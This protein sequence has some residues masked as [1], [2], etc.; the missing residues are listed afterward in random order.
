MLAAQTDQHA[1]STGNTI[2]DAL[3]R[4]VRKHRSKT[5]L[6]YGGRA[7]SF[8]ALD[9]A[10]DRVARALLDA[11][12]KPGQR[13]GAF[14][15]NSDAYVLLWLACTRT[16]IVHVP[17]NYALGPKELRYILEQAVVSG[18]VTDDALAETADAACEG[19]EVGLRGSF[20]SEAPGE[21]DVLRVVRSDDDV[22][23]PEV[24]LDENAVAQFLYT[25][26]TTSLPKGAMMTH[27]AL[28]AEYM[29]CII[30]LD[31]KADEVGLAALP[32]YHSAQMHVFLMPSLL[33]G[34]TTVLI[35]APAPTACFEQIEAH[36]V[37]SFFAPPTVWI[38]LLRDEGFDTYDLS[39]LKKAY[40]GAS[41]MPTPVLQE[42]RERMP[43]V[44]LYNC[45][46]QSEIA[47][48]ATVLRPE[49]HEARPASAG[50]PLLTVTTRVVDEQMN[51]VAAGEHGEIVHRSPQLLVGYWDKP[52]R[53]EEA[54]RGGW[55]HS[56]DVGYLDEEGYL[57]IVDRLKDVINTGG[58]VVASR[59]VEEA[60]FEHPAVSEVAVI[61]V[62]HERWIEAIVAVV[63]LREGAEA[64]EAELVDHA[65]EHLAGYKL[66]KKVVF[67]D[68]LPRNTA[69]KI[70]KRTLR[71]DFADITF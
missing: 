23:P 42:L 56:G 62:P 31:L 3:R 63:V 46:G 26:G 49:E 47:P 24:E 6:R 68:D 40:Y 30:E 55:F 71:D 50:R 41:I 64:T 20:R 14:G 51:D 32:L 5:A 57:Y 9:A 1:S 61:G 70:L 12:L 28:L 34:A 44:G 43:G 37:A 58:V 18:L 38:G 45:Y 36:G 35:D 21:L 69:G 16:G 22:A 17:I 54:F 52:E 60:L 11:G 59:E 33:I 27:R 65:R 13:L 2:A 48:L 53:T 39:S 15:K 8:E 25:S 66:P 10:A 4:S 19:L 29:A 7:W 67:V